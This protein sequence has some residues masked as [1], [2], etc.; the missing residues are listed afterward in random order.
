MRSDTALVN[1]VLSDTE[2]DR[3]LVITAHPDDVD[4]GAAATIAGWTSAGIEVIYCV[5]TDG[6]AGGFDPA[7]DRADIPGIRRAEQLAAAASVGVTDVRF[8]G[9]TDGTLTVTLGLRRDLSRIIR[10]VRP[11][12]VLVQSPERNWVRIQASHPDHLAAGEAA[13]QAIYPDARNPYAHTELLAVEG[14]AAWTVREVWLMAG[15]RSD[16]YIDV[17]DRFDRKLAALREHHSQV[18]HMDD[19]E[20]MLR[21]W[22]GRNAADAGWELGRLAEA[23]QVLFIE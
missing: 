15:P 22:L 5:I 3:A 4:F 17:T 10:E 20:T 21:D 1:T 13:L 18:D 9:Y 8:L 11:Q 6:D 19:L 14:L 16:H 23:F 2:I 7:V 12:R